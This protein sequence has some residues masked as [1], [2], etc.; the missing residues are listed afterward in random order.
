M[1]I[2]DYLFYL[3]SF[4]P[5]T[6]PRIAALRVWVLIVARCCELLVKRP[7]E[8]RRTGCRVNRI[9]G[10]ERREAN[11][12]LLRP[13]CQIADAVTAHEREAVLERRM[14]AVS[15]E[16][17]ATRETMQGRLAAL[18]QRMAALVADRQ[19]M[20]ARLDASQQQTTAATEERVAVTQEM[21]A[22]LAA[23]RR[24]AGAAG[25]EIVAV[26]QQMEAR[27]AA[28]RSEAA[29][30]RVAVTQQMEA[31]FAGLQRE[32][33]ARARVGVRPPKEDNLVR[34]RCVGSFDCAGML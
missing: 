24:E 17:V 26:T 27:L 4:Y 28:V 11:E 5:C 14:A 31:R 3:G 32:A 2:H 6:I 25:E 7:R 19:H 13:L 34:R 33:A 30:A 22:Q 15:G 29:A 21:E 18:E 20:Q 23:L 16:L 8:E 1:S 10:W 12:L 9:Y